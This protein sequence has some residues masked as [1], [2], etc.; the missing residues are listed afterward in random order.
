MAGLVVRGTI[1]DDI[2]HAA[3]HLIT[4]AAQNVMC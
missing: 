3:H 2:D 4:H 1:D